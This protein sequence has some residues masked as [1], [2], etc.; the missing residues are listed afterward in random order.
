MKYAELRKERA[1]TRN[2]ARDSGIGIGLD[3]NYEV[4]LIV[5]DSE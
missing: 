5:N 4:L 1:I 3:P 2:A